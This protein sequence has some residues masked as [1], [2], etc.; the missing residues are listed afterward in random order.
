MQVV[1]AL[2]ASGINRLLLPADLGGLQAPTHDVMDVIEALA[3]VDGS[4]AWCAAIGAGS[5]V[6]AGY[7]NES[8]ARTVFADPDQGSATMFSPGGR[9]ELAESRGPLT[10]RWPFASNCLHSAWA[11][12]GAEVDR[13]GK[14]DPAPTIAFVRV[15][16]LTIEDTWD[17]A[18]LRGSGS[19]HVSADHVDVELDHCCT[20]GRHSLAGGSPLAPP[21]AHRAPPDARGG[22]ARDR[23]RRP[24]RDRSAGA[25][26]TCGP[27]RDHR[28]R[29][30]VA[31]RVRRSR[32]QPP[33][34]L[35]PRCATFCTRR[36][37]WR[38]WVTLLND[39]S[40]HGSGWPAC[41]PRM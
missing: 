1:A 35:A 39:R 2:R 37:S 4:T 11:G 3:A 5:N 9:I 26:R 40:G 27:A 21:A 17:T 18:G 16:D 19:H 20:L 7:M 36:T 8:G 34:G 29:P 10:G 14:V 22:L 33:R 12:L 28:R 25:R 32:Q 13:G 23:A 41:T 31:R 38:T 6:F 24:R 30:C 15:S